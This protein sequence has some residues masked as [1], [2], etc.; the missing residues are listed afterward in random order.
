MSALQWLGV[1]MAGIPILAM[2]IFMIRNCWQ[3]FVFAVTM[4][5]LIVAGIYLATGAIS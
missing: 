1:F 2:C 4:T 5:T 3:V